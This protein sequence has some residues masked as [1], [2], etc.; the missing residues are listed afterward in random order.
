VIRDAICGHA[1]RA[2]RDHYEMPTVQDMEKALELFP[3]YK[4]DDQPKQ[5]HRPQT[6]P[7]VSEGTEAEQLTLLRDNSCPRKW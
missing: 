4:I 7:R 1:P 3:R 2:V 6:A 5:S